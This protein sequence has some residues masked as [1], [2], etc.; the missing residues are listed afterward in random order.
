MRLASLAR[1]L[2]EHGPDFLPTSAPERMRLA[3]L[4][5]ILSERGPDFLPTSA[6][7]RM[8]LASL[9]RILS[10][11][12]PDFMSRYAPERIR[13]SDLRLR[14]PTLYPA[15]LRAL[16]GSIPDPEGPGE[17]GCMR[18]KPSSVPA[19][20]ACASGREGHFSGRRVAT[21]LVQPTRDSNGAGRASSLLG[22]APGGVCH[23]ASVT[24]GPVRSYRTLSPLPVLPREPSAVCSLWHFPSA[25][26]ARAL[27]GTLPCGARTFLR[28]SGRTRPPATLTRMLPEPC[29][30]R[31]PKLHPGGD[32]VKARRGRG[33]AHPGCGGSLTAP[34]G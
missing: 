18:S 3:S 1:I 4:A 17:R 10:E 30:F 2:S 6:P 32:R 15:E 26:A 20:E 9:A 29:S 28:R 13:T 21:P 12:G 31:A 34:A 27:P 16:G 23:A 7:E 11:H 8:R 33:E 14:R 24:G 5:R 25:L 19:A 22:L